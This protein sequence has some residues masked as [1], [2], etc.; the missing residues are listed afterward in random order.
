MYSTITGKVGDQSYHYI[1]TMRREGGGVGVGK[2]E[3]EN[4]RE[5]GGEKKKG[6]EGRE[7]EEEGGWREGGGRDFLL[8]Q[9]T[10]ASSL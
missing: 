9:V 2:G 8:R 3:W 5:G 6:E 4:R 1:T 10:E 7:R